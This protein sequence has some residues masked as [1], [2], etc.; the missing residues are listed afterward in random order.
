MVISVPFGTSFNETILTPLYKIQVDP[1]GT[2]GA[3]DGLAFSNDGSFLAASDNLAN[4]YLYRESD[5]T[6]QQQFNHTTIAFAGRHQSDGEINA[7]DFSV[8]DKLMLTGVNDNGTKVWDVKTGALLYHLNQGTNT[9]GAAFSPNGKW[10]A[11]AANGI[12][13]VFDV[14][15]NFVEIASINASSDEVNTVDWSKDSEFLILAADDGAPINK[16]GVQLYTTGN[17]TNPAENWQFIRDYNYPDIA[18]SARIS[19]DN[20]YIAVSGRGPHGPNT[21][22]NTVPGLVLIYDLQTGELVADLK[23][24]GNLL[25]QPLDDRDRRV[26]IEE[27][28]WTPDGNYL[29]T[30]GL[31]D[32]VARIYRAKD[33][34]LVGY[35]QAQD[36]NRAIEKIDI[37]VDGKVAFGGDEGAVYVYQFNAPEIL[38]PIQS[39]RSPNNLVTIEV[40]N[41]DT[42][43]SQGGFTWLDRN[44]ATASGGK[45]VQAIA[46]TNT[47]IDQIDTNFSTGDPLVDSPK[48]DFRVNFTETGTY[49]VWVRGRE[50]FLGG[51]SVHVGL[52]G[53]EVATAE[54]IRIGDNNWG[55]DNQNRSRAAATIQITEL[56]ESTVNLFMREVGTSVDKILLTTNPNFDPNL[57]NGGLGPNESFRASSTRFEA[58]DALLGV[59]LNVASDNPGF[60]G[61]GFVEFPGRVG[62]NVS[63]EWTV[64]VANAG[65]YF[66][67]FGYANGRNFD[68]P[69][70]LSVNNAVVDP[71]ISFES[72]GSWSNW[73]INSST[74]SLAGGTN[75]I[76]LTANSIQG[77]D[78]DYLDLVAV[79]PTVV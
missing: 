27:I 32:G 58:E 34:S 78:F 59:G 72:T 8:D 1:A 38:D 65:N 53:E 24:Q 22:D 16:S 31:I 4:A 10:M 35:V 48:L 21:P 19:P 44:D 60:S 66:L 14:Q 70:E 62:N 50:G 39:D 25:P 7:I 73:E 40:E 12:V 23:H 67:D 57:V 26:F 79:P 75:T 69:M 36:T 55:W 6:L 45:A 43:L 63:L 49:Y 41:N 15:N 33:W 28:A 20:Q 9:D 37:S 5:L 29:F 46:T 3:T 11:A 18:K 2:L 17:S 71:S 56:G 13:K 61:T 54:R 76:K 42:N 64:N 47:T 51:N 30:S 77:A 68:R 52:N 74:V